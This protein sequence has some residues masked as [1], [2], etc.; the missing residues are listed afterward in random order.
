[1][2]KT[3]VQVSVKTFEYFMMV[4]SAHALSGEFPVEL[5]ETSANPPQAD[6]VERATC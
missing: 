5:S 2:G 6:T 4:A 3:D 1:M